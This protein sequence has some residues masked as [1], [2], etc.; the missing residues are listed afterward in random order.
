MH[1]I[2]YTNVM[3][4]YIIPFY[5]IQSNTRYLGLVNNQKALISHLFFL[6][7]SFFFGGAGGVGGGPLKDHFRKGGFLS[8]QSASVLC[9][10]WPSQV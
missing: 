4:K 2:S 3:K 9:K 7:F 8:S 10:L 5:F 1:R 6:F